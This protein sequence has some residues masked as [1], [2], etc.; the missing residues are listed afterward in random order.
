[1]PAPRAFDR[2]GCSDSTK[3]D[4]C[5]DDTDNTYLYVRILSR[6]APMSKLDSSIAV[7]FLLAVTPSVCSAQREGA[8]AGSLAASPV[9]FAVT[10]ASDIDVEPVPLPAP[11]SAKELTLA[12][13]E[14]M[15]LVNNPSLTE[16][17][18]QISALQGE[19]V[20]VGLWPNPIVGY[21]ATDVGLDGT[22]GQQGGFVSQQVITA[23]KLQLNREIVTQKIEWAE[24]Q[25]SAQRLRVLND[26]R[27]AYYEALLAQR[28]V[29]ILK[30]LSKLSN[31]ARNVADQLFQAQEGS[32]VN[33]LQAVVESDTVRIDVDNANSDYI[34]SWR[35]LASVVGAADMS[36]TELLGDYREL[37]PELT[38]SD[39]LRQLLHK[40]PEIGAALANLQRAEWELRLATAGRIPDVNMSTSVRYDN[41]AQ[42]TLADVRIGVPLVI[43]DRNQ[44]NIQRAEA[45]VAAAQ[46]AM[47][48]V[49]LDLQNRLAVVFN[50]YI[51][52]RRQAERYA[53]D[54]LPNAGRAFE[55]IEE[56]YRNGESS[57]LGVLTAQRTYIRANL[58][59]LDSL[60]QARQD[61]ARI[62]GLLLTGS[63]Q[64]LQ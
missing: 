27:M 47:E 59:Y 62:R 35:R 7:L 21:D 32:R 9:R 20:Q 36:P 12:D 54:I 58:A 57:Y 39:T 17:R 60:R 26:V 13:L 50:R 46:R 48:R 55:L 45:G 28:R 5:S 1:M 31:E 10:A 37:P 3:R 14:A 6:G 29:E 41:A 53:R 56:A 42:N 63:L 40:S 34:A 30:E 11:L 24:Q 61:D 8:P 25:W 49:E 23:K 2:S 44:G 16:A 51:K 33:L 4:D 43:F 15:A 18:A 64:S 52:A 19:W 22:A 38:W